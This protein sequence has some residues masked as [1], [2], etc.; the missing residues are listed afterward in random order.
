MGFAL[1]DDKRGYA[2]RDDTKK[3]ALDKSPCL[4]KYQHG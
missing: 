1:R 3:L 2:L 4:L